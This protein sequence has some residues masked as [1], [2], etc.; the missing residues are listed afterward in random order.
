MSEMNEMNKLPDEALD[1]VS[2]GVNRGRGGVGCRDC[3]PYWIRTTAKNGLHCRLA[4]ST[5]AKILKTY[6]YGHRLKIN[7][8]TTD[9]EWYRLLCNH[10]EGGTCYG[11]IYKAYTERV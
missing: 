4:P 7:G 10:P 5:S 2:G 6:E 3:A 11:F 8:I 9:G 1:V